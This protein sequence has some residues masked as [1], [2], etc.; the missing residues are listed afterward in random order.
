MYYSVETQISDQ[1]DFYYHSLEVGKYILPKKF[2]AKSV[3]ASL[4][5]KQGVFI[6]K[7][8]NYAISTDEK[9]LCLTKHHVKNENY[10]Y[11]SRSLKNKI[12]DQTILLNFPS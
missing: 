8:S 11:I 10:I 12:L 9:V 2:L 6:L 3:H 7:K 5:M 4:Q 1:F